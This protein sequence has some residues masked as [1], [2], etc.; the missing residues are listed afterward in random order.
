MS[1]VTIGGRRVGDGAPC[2]I[3]AEAGS[4]HNGSLEQAERL[5]ELAAS[6][7]ADAVKFQ[8]FRAERLYPRRAGESGYL[9]LARPIYD[10]IQEME[11]PYEWLPKLARTAHARGIALLASAFD[12]ESADRLDPFVEA[13]KVASYEMTHLPLVEHIAKKGKPMIVSTGAAELAE[14]EELLAAIRAAGNDAVALMQCTAAYPA[15]PD[16]LNLRGIPAM[17]AAFRLPVGFSDHS[18]DPLVGPLCAVALG[19]DLIEKHVTFSNDLPGPDHRFAIEPEELCRMVAKIREAESALGSG[20]K[21]VHAV[22]RELHSFA[23][24]SVFTT[25]DVRA[26]GVLTTRNVAVLRR[27]KLAAGLEPKALPMVLGRRSIRAIPAE[28]AIR[29]EDLASA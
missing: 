23:R 13:H 2:F 11:M 27:G 21:R 12:E 18:R 15:P 8:L 29:A 17:K 3:I 10:I 16:S 9:K 6:A 26:G 28:T 19:A 14:V 1:A 7:G 25:R 5:I 4:N 20:E 22:E 24:R